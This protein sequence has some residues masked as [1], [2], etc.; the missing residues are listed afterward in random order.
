MLLLLPSHDATP[1]VGFPQQVDQTLSREG[2]Q[3]EEQDG[4]AGHIE[5]PPPLLLKDTT[6]SSSLGE[7]L[8]QPST[9]T[10]H[11]SLARPLALSLSLSAVHRLPVRNYWYE[12]KS[13]FP[14]D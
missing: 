14:Q 13:V 11:L 8:D 3:Q 12:E 2:P 1:L 6:L 4:V 7:W 10:Q 9:S 5:G